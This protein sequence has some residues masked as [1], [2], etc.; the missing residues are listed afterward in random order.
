MPGKTIAHIAIA[1]QTN[2][3]MTNPIFRFPIDKSIPPLLVEGLKYV[4][5][6][7]IKNPIIVKIIFLYLP[8]ISFLSS[9]KTIGI[10]K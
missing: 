8:I 10:E 6:T 7:T 2:V 4:I 9:L 3:Y 5:A 1:P